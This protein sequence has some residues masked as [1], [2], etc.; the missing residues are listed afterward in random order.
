M[1]R[2]VPA[3]TTLSL[4]HITIA[5]TGGRGLYFWESSAN[6]APVAAAWLRPSSVRYLSLSVSP[7]RLYCPSVRLVYFLLWYFSRVWSLVSGRRRL[8]YLA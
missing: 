1:V 8:Q 5:N 2:V 4:D 7:L 6:L 3:H